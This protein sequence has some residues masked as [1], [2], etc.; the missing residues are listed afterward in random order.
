LTQKILTT[1]LA[2]IPRDVV[3]GVVMAAKI[4]AADGSMGISRIGAV[5]SVDG[6]RSRNRGGQ[7]IEQLKTNQEQMARVIAKASEQSLRPKISAPPPR[8]TASP[9][10]K[11]VPTL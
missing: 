7:G 2:S 9:T 11:P 8:P 5:A 3:C 4:A 10:R 6:A 1:G